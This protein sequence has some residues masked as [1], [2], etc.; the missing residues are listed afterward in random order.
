MQLPTLLLCG[1]ATL[2][3]QQIVNAELERVLTLGQR[4]T[5]PGATHD[6]WVEQPDACGAA[7]LEFLREHP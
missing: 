6:M 3:I 2:P 4:V 7:V 5:L 1:D